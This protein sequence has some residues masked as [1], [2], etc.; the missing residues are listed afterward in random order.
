MSRPITDK[1]K[2]LVI[3][4]EILERQLKIYKSL[5]SAINSDLF[6]NLPNGLASEIKDAVESF[7]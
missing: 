1:T 3:K 4:I 5:L 6:H 7:N 2:S